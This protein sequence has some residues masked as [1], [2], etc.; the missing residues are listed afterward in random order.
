MRARAKVTLMERR[1]A[2][3][4]HAVVTVSGNRGSFRR[5]PCEDCPWRVD[6]VGKFPAEAFRLSANTGAER[7]DI[8]EDNRKKLIVRKE[9]ESSDGE[10]SL[11]KRFN[12]ISHTFNEI[13]HTFGCHRS[14]TDHPTTC[15]GYILRSAGSLS[16]RLAVLRGHF[17]SENVSSGGHRLFRSYYEMA[18]ANGVP[19]DDPALAAC[20]PW[21][22]S[23][24]RR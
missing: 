5:R 13:S 19:P 9:T 6:A 7:V 8:S 1:P 21:Q 17:K 14:G 2:G 16:W 11:N 10:T 22:L 3:D 4:E 20:R 12:E 15:A 23:D 18:V 24:R